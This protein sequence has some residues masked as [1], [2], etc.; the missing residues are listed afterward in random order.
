MANPFLKV[1]DVF[2]IDWLFNYDSNNDKKIKSQYLPSFETINSQVE[3]SNLKDVNDSQ[4][5][6]NNSLY[7]DSTTSKW[8]SGFIDHVNL[9][10]KGTNTHSQID[11][12]L[13]STSGTHGVV[14]SFVGT[15]DTQTLTNKT[16]TDSTTYFQNNGDNTKKIQFSLFNITSGNTR[17]LMM[18]DSD[19]L[20]VGTDTTQ[21]ISNKTLNDANI[22]FQN[23][24]DNTKKITFD[25]SLI[26]SGQTRL[27]QFP[28]GGFTIVGDTTVQTIRNK[29]FDNTN[30]F[31]NVRG[32]FCSDYELYT[33]ILI[34]EHISSPCQSDGKFKGFFCETSNSFSYDIYI[35]NG[36]LTNGQVFYYQAIGTGSLNLGLLD[37]NSYLIAQ[38]QDNAVLMVGIAAGNTYKL[39]FYTANNNPWYNS[40][41]PTW[42]FENIGSNISSYSSIVCFVTKN[43]GGT[44]TGVFDTPSGPSSGQY[45]LFVD[46]SGYLNKT[47]VKLQGINDD[48]INNYTYLLMSTPNASFNFIYLDKITSWF[49]I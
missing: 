7:W 22:F 35:P 26:S 9:L 3:L 32:T 25:L 16:F 20:L 8:V 19:T 15:S 42:K 43:Y 33:F 45:Q 39:T 12:H 2:D 38:S 24:N 27:I 14:G 44:L 47:N 31:N 29:T 46:L 1:K 37:V 17:L 5:A 18:P 30:T 34:S 41:N 48:K 10:N 49:Q 28:D 23:N 4:I 6:N 13:S 21:T 40:S 11:T 36:G